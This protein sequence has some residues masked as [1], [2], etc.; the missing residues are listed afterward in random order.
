MGFGG[1]IINDRFFFVKKSVVIEIFVLFGN[2]N[3]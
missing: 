2:L 1:K 3:K